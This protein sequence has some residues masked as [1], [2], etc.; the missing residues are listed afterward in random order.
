MS[1]ALRKPHWIAGPVGYQI[2]T[3]GDDG[4]NRFAAVAKWTFVG[5]M[6]NGEFRRW[7][8]TYSIQTRKFGTNTLLVTDWDRAHNDQLAAIFRPSA[9]LTSMLPK[10]AI[11]H[12]FRA[13]I[14]EADVAHVLAL[15]MRGGKP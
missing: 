7:V 9:V 2:T 4:V 15:S 11:V 13:M 14:S 8:L 12:A 10:G 6:A 5:C 3:M 1:A